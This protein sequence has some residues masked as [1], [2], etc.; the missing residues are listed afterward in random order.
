MTPR[1]LDVAVVRAR[2]SA[3]NELVDALRVIGEVDGARLRAD[4]IVRLAVERALTAAVDLV[5]SVCSHVV[6][7]GPTPV[8]DTYREVIRLAGGNAVI[9]PALASSL[10]SAVGL[11]NVLVHEYVRADL[12]LVAAAV[13]GASQDLAAFIAQVSA[14][15][16]RQD[17]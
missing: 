8:P 3:L 7:S 12:D 14:W 10:A 13:P 16:L 6:A 4:V 15:V 1:K 2:L 11:R 5:V 9:D 17:G